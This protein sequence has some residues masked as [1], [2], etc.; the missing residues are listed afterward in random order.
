[1]PIGVWPKDWDPKEGKKTFNADTPFLKHF[2]NVKEHCNLLQNLWNPNSKG[3]NG[4]WPKVPVVLSGGFV[5]RSTERN[6]GVGRPSLDQVMAK[7]IGHKTPLLSLELGIDEP[8]AGIDSVG[9]GFTRLYGNY[10]S[11]RGPRTPVANERIPL[12]AFNRLFK[13]GKDPKIPS[14]NADSQ[15]F[16]ESMLYDSTSILDLVRSDAKSLQ[17][18]MSRNDREKI[19]EYFESVRAVELQIRNSMIPQNL[20]KN[21]TTF[22]FKKSN[23]GIPQD[24]ETH[25]KLMLD[26]M[27]LAFWTDKTRISTFMLGNAQSNHNYSFLPGVNGTFHELSHHS[28]KPEVRKQYK[29]IVH[30][31][32]KHV[33]YFLERMKN[34]TEGEHGSLLDNSM[35]LFGSTIK[36]GNKHGEEDLP[37]LLAGKAQGKIKSGRIITAPKKTPLSNLYVSMLDMMGIHRPKFGDSTGRIKLS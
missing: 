3:R 8:R 17:R 37:L 22:E 26:I 30:Y 25:V 33:A 24:H 21:K 16:K 4:H 12:Y 32:L 7:T 20:W 18:K 11:W 6:L 2:E 34:M 29:S 5:E 31:N 15:D 1:M 23:E 14:L 36:D 35:V 13:S 19:D 28:E 10:I 9:G 27:L